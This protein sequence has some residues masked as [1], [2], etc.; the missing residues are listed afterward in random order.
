[1][2]KNFLTAVVCTAAAFIIL[3]IFSSCKTTLTSVLQEPVLSFQ[4][5]EL[6]SINL[7]GARILCKVQVENPNSFDIPFPDTDWELF[8]NTNSFTSGTFKDNQKIKARNSVV[9]DVPVDILYRELFSSFKSLIG[10][11]EAAYKAALDLHF[12]LPLLKEKIWTFEKTGTLPIPQLPRVRTPSVR[13]ESANT[14]RAEMT[15]TINIEN[16]NP[17]EVPIPKIE[18]DYQLN[19]NS[20]IKGNLDNEGILAANK[21]TPVTFKLVVTYA[22]LFRSFSSLLTQFEVNTLLVVTCDFG[23]PYLSSGPQRYEV[24]GKLPVLR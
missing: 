23:I 7:D 11:K 10:T 20:F 21:T 19:K 15:V 13:M 1:M 16:P 8:V 9:I 22:D 14:T 24:P 2:R 12:P 17:F 3:M 5:A 4:S 18:Y 6:S